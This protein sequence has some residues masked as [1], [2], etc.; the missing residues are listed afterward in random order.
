MHPFCTLVLSF[1][2]LAASPL[3]SASVSSS[4]K[5]CSHFFYMQ[6]PPAG[7]EGADLRRVCQKYSDKLRYATLYD[8]SRRLPLYS[9]YIFRKSDGKRTV[10]TPWMYEPQLVSDNE[11]GNMRALPLAED[12]PPLIEHSQAVLE[13]YTDAVDY[14]RGPLNPDLH[15]SEPDD[16]S[17]TYT[18]TNVVPLITHFLDASWKPYLD[19]IRRRLNNFCHGKA[20]MVAGVT[21]PGGTLQRESRDRL[22]IP[23]HLWL[24]YCCPRFD[25]NSPHEV[26]FMFPGYA[27][28]ALND[29]TDHGVAEVPLKTLES[30]LKSQSDAD[31]DLAIFYKGCVSET[32]FRKKRDLTRGTKPTYC[33]NRAK[34]NK[35]Q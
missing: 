19:T 32:T 15:Q 2:L 10:D 25:R 24:A 12:T 4:F 3:A 22:A 1:S 6:T 9:A 21:V 23:K 18:L 8:G 7:M 13:D 34:S 28:Y 17:S 20:F 33:T 31:R 27:G 35:L 30:F 5:G 16:K 29:H 26:R 14:K 11:G